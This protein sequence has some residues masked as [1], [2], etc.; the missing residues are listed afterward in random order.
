MKNLLLILVML[1]TGITNAQ[2]N[3]EIQDCDIFESEIIEFDFDPSNCVVD[4]EIVKSE[5]YDITDLFFSELATYNEGIA[6]Y[7]TY[8]YPFSDVVSSGYLI[9]IDTFPFTYGAV[10]DVEKC[11]GTN[12]AGEIIVNLNINEDKWYELSN[13]EYYGNGDV[14]AL[15]SLKKKMIIFHEL[16]HAVLGLDHPCNTE[17][18]IMNTS[19]C[20]RAPGSQYNLSFPS[21]FPVDNVTT[22]ENARKRMFL[23]TQGGQVLADVCPLTR[24]DILRALSV[25]GE[26]SVVVNDNKRSTVITDLKNGLDTTKTIDPSIPNLNASAWAYYKGSIEDVV[27]AYLNN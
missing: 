24:I 12:N 16:G 21:D 13:D 18:D 8:L 26:V 4:F 11:Q 17:A 9:T 14:K 22:F 23:G 19:Q 25:E 10:A 5:L 7:P 3:P 2:C 27:N 1:I 20:P 6:N 15:A